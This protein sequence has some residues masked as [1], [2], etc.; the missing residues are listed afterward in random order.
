M[1]IDADGSQLGI[2]RKSHIPD[3]PG[4]QEKYYFT[5]GDT[6][7]RVFKTRFADIGVG[8]CSD[9]WYP[10]AAR[11]MALKGA[12]L[13]LYPTAI[14]SEPLAP[15]VDTCAQWQR[16]MQGHASANMIPVIASN[17]VGKELAISNDLSITFY[18]S[19][20][21][22]DHTGSIVSDAGRH[23]ET[24]L[25]YMY[26]LEEIRAA[27]Q[28]GGLFRD[29]RPELYSL[30]SSYDGLV[31]HVLTGNDRRHPPP[32]SDTNQSAV[33]AAAAAAVVANH[34]HQGLH[35][36]FSTPGR[37]GVATT[38][39]AGGTG[40]TP[41]SQSLPSSSPAPLPPPPP[42]TANMVVTTG[43]L[44]MSGATTAPMLNGT[45]AKKM[46]DGLVVTGA[47]AM[48]HASNTVGMTSTPVGDGRVNNQQFDLHEASFIGEVKGTSQRRPRG[49]CWVCRAKTTYECKICHPGPVPLCN[50]TARE[51]W[52][53]YHAGEVTSFIPNKRGR[54][55]RKVDN[56][57]AGATMQAAAAAAA[58][59]GVDVG[60]AVVQ[61]HVPQ[62]CASATTVLP[63]SDIVPSE[64]QQ[65]AAV[66]AA[67]EN[68]AAEQAVG[69]PPPPPDGVVE[70]EEDDHV[71]DKNQVQVQVQVQVS[72]GD[73]SSVGGLLA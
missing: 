6:G 29:R 1:V 33:V 63:H 25:T 72:E 5:P 27:R 57:V 16:C 2:Y 68:A 9:Q 32:P 20:F 35:T 43:G 42:T 17:R 13:L 38:P 46:E 61:T 55:R 28:R 70:N 15:A 65:V 31:T 71:D 18:G 56:G 58:A 14:G 30:L 7:F 73:A 67:Q 53:K 34:H 52:W 69:V 3:G 66:A 10:E 23:Q 48:M 19:S 40:G 41:M 8:I 64:Q 39:N 54:K 47:H 4:Y 62:T 60:A 59:A 12:E 49:R 26:N 44:N 11:I 51:C 45:G 37:G 24:V 50:R 36:P 21:M 22:T